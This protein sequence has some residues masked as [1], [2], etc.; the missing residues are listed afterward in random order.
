MQSLLQAGASAE[1]F[2]AVDRYVANVT[3]YAHTKSKAKAR[4]GSAPAGS[5]ELTAYLDRKFRVL[6]R[7]Q[8]RIDSYI[9]EKVNICK[10]MVCPWYGTNVYDLHSMETP[11]LVPL[12]K[13]MKTLI[14]IFLP[15]LSRHPTMTEL[16]CSCGSV[17]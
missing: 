13:N 14:P 8:D 2:A 3:A 1:A 17:P 15:A 10:R 7:N 6:F 9:H 12:K 4:A 11:R 5:A 16:R